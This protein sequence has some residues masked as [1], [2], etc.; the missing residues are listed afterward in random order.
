MDSPAGD[1]GLFRFL[2]SEDVPPEQFAPLPV[3]Q[4]HQQSAYHRQAMTSPP[5]IGPRCA[6]AFQAAPRLRHGRADHG[7]G[8]GARE[9]PGVRFWRTGHWSGDVTPEA[10]VFPIDAI[11][12][13][14]L[15]SHRE[16]AES[17]KSS[18]S[19]TTSQKKPQSMQP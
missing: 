10:E 11:L 19:S 2:R 7:A 8:Q 16:F 1:G 15:V 17:I 6:D 9:I 5:Q 4:P 3:R 18:S 14:L 12:P 13:F